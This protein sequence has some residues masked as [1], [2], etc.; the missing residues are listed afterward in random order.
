MKKLLVIILTYEASQHIAALLARIPRHLF[1]PDAPYQCD[2]LLLDDASADD[3]FACASDY[4]RSHPLPI[5]LLRN[6][7]NQGYGGN[8]KIGYAYAIAHGYDYALM[9]H[10]D[11]QYPPEMIDDLMRP[12]LEG[13]ADAVLGSRMMSY[14]SARAGGMPFYKLI[15]N[16]V[17]T[18]VQNFLLRSRLS[19]FHTGFRAYAL[20]AMASVPFADNSNDFDFDTDILIQFILTGKRIHEIS[21][22]THYGDEIC[23]VNGPKYAF[24]VV[25]NTLLARCQALGIFY[26]PKFDFEQGA[27]N[28]PD[29]TGFFSSHSWAVSH[30]PA[31]ASALDIGC[32]P[33]M[34]VLRALLAKG[35]RVLALGSPSALYPEIPARSVDF[36]NTGFSLTEPEASCRHILLLDVIEHLDHPEEFIKALRAQV[37]DST[38]LITSANVGFIIVRLSLLLG[39][40]N[41]GKRGILDLGHK[42]LFTFASLKRLLRTHGYAIERVEG[43]PAPFPLAISNPLLARSFLAMNRFLACLWPSL[44]AYQI[45]IVARP[46]PTYA[47]LIRRAELSS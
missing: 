25:R 35:C 14:Q 33:Q 36:N 28:Y 16:V 4:V 19:E 10:G 40:F 3:T 41:Y 29:K 12:L 39:Q 13:A 45:A 44:F 24:Q 22:P 26:T 18:H 30:V 2:L 6:P 23:H 8:Q 37:E 7:I 9:L 47:Q 20:S 11:G 15:G 21:I 27:T 46:L 38:L 17:L 42:R 1:A 34:P 31:G 43:I 5:R 32:G